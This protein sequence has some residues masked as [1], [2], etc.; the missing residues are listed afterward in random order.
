M[1]QTIEIEIP[2]REDLYLE[3]LVLDYNGTLAIDDEPI[4]GV[5]ERLEHL[6]QSLSVHVITADT[7]GKVRAR[8]SGLHCHISI[9]P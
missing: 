2:G 8:L 5:P 6:S 7:F 4:E 3:H 9:L 1:N